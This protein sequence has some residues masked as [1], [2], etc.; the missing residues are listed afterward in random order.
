MFA[1]ADCN[2]FYASCERLFAPRLE[3]KPIVVLSNNDGCVIARS[4]EAKALGIPMGAPYFKLSALI[5]EHGVA[6]FSSNYTLYGDL[7]HRVIE[8]IRPFAPQLEV[9]S[10]DECFLDLTGLQVNLTDHAQQIV[11]TVKQWVGIPISIGIAPTKTLAKLTNALVKQGRSLTGS[12]LDWST[13]PSPEAVLASVPVESIWGIAKRSGLRLRQLGISD[14][15]ALREADG[16]MLRQE[17]GVVM[18]RI[19]HELRGTSCL[20]LESISPLRKQ[21]IVS[22]SFGG[23]QTKLAPIQS[24]VASFAAR[25]GEKLRGD[26]Q[27]TQALTVFLHTSRFE[28]DADNS[29]ANSLTLG[30]DTPCQ[31]TSQLIRTA[32]R[33]LDQIFRPGYAYQKAGIILLDLV[34]PQQAQPSLFAPAP[35]QVERS[36]KLMDVLDRV[37]RANG[38]HSLRFASE[39]VDEHWRGRSTLRSPA[40]STNWR[41]IPFVQAM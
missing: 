33:A 21:I 9:Y 14:A 12:V 35:A 4:N 2:N 7:S 16:R 1:L 39:A 23:R 17:F 38:K 27:C 24:A 34:T 3:G 15:L 32:L 11:R 19:A 40:F 20:P 36:R 13:L 5:K 25:A 18:E 6:V 41:E 10:I 26:N 29:Y 8:T 31:D 22:R 30:F 28:T 37:N